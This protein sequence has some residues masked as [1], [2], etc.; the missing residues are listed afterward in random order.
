MR[1][2]TEEMLMTSPDPCRRMTGTAARIAAAAASTLRRKSASTSLP[3][4]SAMPECIPMPALFTRMSMPP[5]SSTVVLTIRSRA[6]VSVTS[7][8]RAIALPPSALIEADRSLSASPFREARTTWA[9]RRANS[10]AMARP[11]PLEAPVTIVRAPLS[12]M[13]MLTAAAKVGRFT[14]C[15]E[16]GDSV[17]AARAFLLCLA[18]DS[19]ETP[20]LLMRFVLRLRLDRLDGCA[21]DFSRGGVQPVDV[22]DFEGRPLAERQQASLMQDLVGVGV[23]DPSDKGLVAQ[24][25]FQLTRM[26]PDPLR[27]LAFAD[28][29]R[30]GT[31]LGPSG[32]RRQG[33]GRNPVDTAHLDRV[34][35]AQFFAPFER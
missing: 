25:V 33:T 32:N 10:S 34:E 22:L 14:S 20:I 26:A 31:E 29:E 15:G 6:V 4:A 30:I 13:S 16:L 1:P 35:K 2:A 17:A 23:A 28:G 24:Q 5:S 7:V 9:P 11:I 18:V 12:R 3:A 27:E 21:Q 19:H 8:G